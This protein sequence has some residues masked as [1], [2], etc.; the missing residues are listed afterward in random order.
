MG[1][2]GDDISDTQGSMSHPGEEKEQ[3][4]HSRAHRCNDRL[5]DLVVVRGELRMSI[6]PLALFFDSRSNASPTLAMFM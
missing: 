2:V 1:A 3:I 5:E 4:H 6:A